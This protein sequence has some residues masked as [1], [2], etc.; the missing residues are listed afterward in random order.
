MMMMDYYGGV[1][2]EAF[3]Q[4]V[5]FELS[6]DDRSQAWTGLWVSALVMCVAS[7]VPGADNELK[8]LKRGR[9]SVDGRR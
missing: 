1:V 8:W 2:N 6:P 5:T 3:S 4:G 7:V 9:Q